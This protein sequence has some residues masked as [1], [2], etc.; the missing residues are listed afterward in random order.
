MEPGQPAATV[1][2]LL[3]EHFGYRELRPLQTRVLEPLEAGRDVLAVL[4][5]GADP[6]QVIRDLAP[7]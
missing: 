1:S 3:W 6:R 2:Q 7:S 4:P 5:T